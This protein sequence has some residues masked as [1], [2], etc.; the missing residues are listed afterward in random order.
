MFHIILILPADDAKTF[1]YLEDIWILRFKNIGIS[2]NIMILPANDSKNLNGSWYTAISNT[3]QRSHPSLK[4]S[5]TKYFETLSCFFLLQAVESTCI[6]GFVC[7][8]LSILAPCPL[9]GQL[10][11]LNSKVLVRYIQRFIAIIR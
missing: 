8:E 4:K 5:Q 6:Q 1:E 11:H 9:L 3:L 2:Y 10:A 7:S